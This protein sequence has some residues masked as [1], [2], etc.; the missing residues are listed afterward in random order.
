MARALDLQA[1]D[2]QVYDLALIILVDEA[3]EREIAMECLFFQAE[4]GIRDIGVTGVQTCALPIF[5]GIKAK[6]D[7]KGESYTVR[8]AEYDKNNK[9]FYI[10][11]AFRKYKNWQ[12]SLVDH[13]KFFHEGWREDHYT[14]HGV[15]GQ[16]DYKKA[17]KGL[18]SRS[19]EHT[20]ELQSR[21]YLVC[22][23]LLEKKK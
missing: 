17:C 14:S 13:A 22:R 23:L 21:Q 7:W 5:F 6:Q 18:Q 20:S 3:L 10:N 19:E 2:E 16:T 12:D 8:T 1:R 9:K 11:A 15:I 4:D